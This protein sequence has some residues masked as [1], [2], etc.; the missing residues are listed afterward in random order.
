MKQDLLSGVPLLNI[1]HK[2]IKLYFQ[3]RVT[4]FLR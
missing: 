2:T 4:M 1:G 3:A